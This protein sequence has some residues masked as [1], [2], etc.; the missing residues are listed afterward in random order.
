LPPAEKAGALSFRGIFPPLVTPFR[1][2][3]SVDS[4]AFRTNF[5]RYEECGLAGYVVLGSN[6]EAV[7]LTEAEKLD[8]VVAARAATRRPLIVGSGLHSTRGTIDLTRRLADA[9]A[10]AALV[11]TPHYYRARMTVAAL[12]RHFEAVADSS[13]IPILLYSVPAFTGLSFPAE[14]VPALGDHAGIVGMKESS[15]DVDLLSGLVASAPRGFSVITGSAPALHASLAHGA[16]GGI[17]A[18]ACCAPRRVV[19]LYDAFV[20][21]DQSRAAELQAALTPLAR[22]VTSGYGVAGLKAAMDFA[23]LRGGEV[24]APLL[25]VDAEG[26]AQIERLLGQLGGA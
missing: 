17:V 8:L 2:D 25:P 15:G 24:R 14:L 9:G 26:R 21:G 5:E 19:A 11:L 7:A 13:P 1:R 16:T 6:G 12:T 22:A 18:L 20:A 4:A 10:D 3:G 23:G